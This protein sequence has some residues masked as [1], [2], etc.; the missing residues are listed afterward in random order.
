MLE[1]ASMTSETFESMFPE[2]AYLKEKKIITRPELKKLERL[3]LYPKN[4]SSIFF[5]RLQNREKLFWNI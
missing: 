4:M 3:F 5:R 1:A 2:L